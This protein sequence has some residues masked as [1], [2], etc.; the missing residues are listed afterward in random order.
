MYFKI[1]YKAVLD[2]LREEDKEKL[3]N[4][5]FGRWKDDFIRLIISRTLEMGK[6]LV[7]IFA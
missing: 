3:W 1:M 5:L 7:Q 4:G 6:V 2:I